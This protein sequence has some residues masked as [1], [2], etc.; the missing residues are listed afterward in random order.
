M[1]ETKTGYV[2]LSIATLL[3]SITLCI[4]VIMQFFT[5]KS[6]GKTKNMKKEQK[7]MPMTKEELLEEIER[8]QRKREIALKIQVIAS[9]A[10]I[11]LDIIWLIILLNS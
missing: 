9:S 11:L 10:V 3:N 6:E 5:W 8:I 1:K 2:L 4:L 7:I